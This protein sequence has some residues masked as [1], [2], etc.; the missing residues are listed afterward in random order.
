[1]VPLTSAHIL[2]ERASPATGRPDLLRRHLEEPWRGH[3][4]RQPRQPDPAPASGPPL[5]PDRGHDGDPET[6]RELRFLGR[7]SAIWIAV[8][9][10]LCL[11][12]AWGMV[13]FMDPAAA[14]DLMSYYLNLS[15]VSEPSTTDPTVT[16]GS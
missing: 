6:A 11:L 3:P 8:S 16:A 15:P 9:V 13:T 2:T 4:A 1:M 10:L 7:L 14:E 12:M 5:R